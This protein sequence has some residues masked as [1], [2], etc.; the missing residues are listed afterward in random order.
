LVRTRS[1]VVTLIVGWAAAGASRS[2]TPA[3]AQ[4]EVPLER[5]PYA[6]RAWI[7]IDPATRLDEQGTTELIEAWRTLVGRFV[8][9][10]WS[11]DVARAEGR[12]AAGSPGELQPDDFDSR[13]ESFDKLWVIRIERGSRR[14][15]RLIGREYDTRTRTLG[16]VARRDVASPA[17]APRELLR[18]AL[19]LFTPS[20]EIGQSVGDRVDLTVQGS[21]LAAADPIGAVTPKGT[22]FVPLRL[23]F[24]PDGS[25]ARIMPVGWTYL[26]VDALDGPTARATLIT[27]LPDPLS[28]RVV[29]AYRLVAVGV[30]PGDVPTRFRFETRP[31]DPKPAAGYTLVAREPPDGD[32]RDVGSTDRDG[33]IALP[34]DF[35][36][37]VVVLRLL[38]GGIEPLVEFPVLPGESDEERVVRVNPLPQTI[39]LETR[40]NALKDEVVDLVAVRARLE[41]RLKTRAEA[42]AWD[43]VKVLLDEFRK[44]KPSRTFIDRL[45]ALRDEATQQQ[46]ETKTAILTRTAQA[47][48]ADTEA[49]ITRYLDDELFQAYET[50][51]KEAQGGAVLAPSDDWKPFTLPGIGAKVL[52]PGTPTAS[53]SEL[54]TG[55]GNLPLKLWSSKYGDRTFAVGVA[56]PLA[57]A[58]PLDAAGVRAS[59]ERMRDQLLTNNPG[60]QL[61]EERPLVHAGV[62]GL[63][64]RMSPRP[65]G[66]APPGRVHRQRALLTDAGRV[67]VLMTVGPAE[68]QDSR[69]AG[70]FFNSFQ[71]PGAPEKAAPP[72]PQERAAPVSAQRPTTN[73]PSNIV[74]STGKSD[75]RISA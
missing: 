11:L 19:R 72:Q 65:D 13:K 15:Y 17:D 74:P 44:L 10:P 38:A 48:F 34:P 52:I 61:V 54:A 43:E 58:P 42:N 29:G 16:T 27:G 32:P 69:D 71:P 39:A 35:G 67:F 9:A 47:Q 41:S 3:P 36:R 6:I 18:F 12:L 28:R 56:E 59:L 63:E 62:V 2:D 5:R 24:K 4:A 40:L 60:F 26:V 33:R 45:S 55:S 66:G 20:A 64:L 7:A 25:L 57:G 46:A 1:L 30:K 8:G 21:L 70:A 22:V 23:F 53:N 50:A 68:G 73:R 75:S 31:P 49:L 37:K 14:G 51:Y